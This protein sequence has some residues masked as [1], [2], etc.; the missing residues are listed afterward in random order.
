MSKLIRCEKCNAKVA[1]VRDA[2][3]IKGII[4]YCPKCHQDLK[5]KI[6]AAKYYAETRGGSDWLK[7]IFGGSF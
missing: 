3:L 1:D 5:S 7:N 4:C 6:A 2:S